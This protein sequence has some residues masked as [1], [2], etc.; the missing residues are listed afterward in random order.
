MPNPVINR[1]PQPEGSGSLIA[2]ARLNE[3][4]SLKRAMILLTAAIGGFS[5]YANLS[6]VVP[7]ESYY[8]FFPPFEEY[9]ANRND[10]LGAEYL[11]IAKSMA[12]DEGFTN[13]FDSLKTAPTAW[14]PP[15]FPTILAVLLWIFDGNRNAVAAVVVICQVCVLI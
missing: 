9:S 8:R 14:V 7:D 15:V 10:H 3:R 6:F 1:V 5:I 4:E 13:P 12:A 2:L 11:N